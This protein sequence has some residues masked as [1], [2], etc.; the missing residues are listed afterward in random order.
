MS[1]EP[2]KYIP[3]LSI[4]ITEDLA[5]R[6]NEV[7]PWGLRKHLFQVLIDSLIDAVEQSGDTVLAAILRRQVRVILAPT[8]KEAH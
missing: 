2:K 5:L 3:R 8:A 7:I 1:K 4:E 6:L